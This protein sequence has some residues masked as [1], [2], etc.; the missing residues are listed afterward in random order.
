MVEKERRN[1]RLQIQISGVDLPQ[2][3][4]SDFYGSSLFIG[5]WYTMAVRCESL[6]ARS[7]FK[8]LLRWVRRRQ[9]AFQLERKERP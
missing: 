5:L 1:K 7:S 2:K 9:L 6:I 4:R 3:A 8:E